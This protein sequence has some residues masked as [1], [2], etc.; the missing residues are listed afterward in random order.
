L[1][2]GIVRGELTILLWGGAFGFAWIYVVLA[3]AWIGWRVRKRLPQAHPIAAASPPLLTFTSDRLPRAPALFSWKLRVEA[4]HST[5]RHYTAILN[6]S[7]TSLTPTWPRGRYLVTARW[8]LADWFGFTR[9]TI[10]PKESVALTVE[11][12]RRE[13]HPPAAPDHRRG[14]TRPRRTGRRAG[15]PFDIRHYVPGDDLRRLHW[16][17]YAHSDSLFVRTAETVPPPTGHQFIVLDIDAASEEAL[18]YRLECLVGWLDNLDAAASEWTVVVPAARLTLDPSNREAL[19]SLSPA[20]LPPTVDTEWPETVSVLTASDETPLIGELIRSRRRVRPV[21]VIQTP[22][23]R[24][25]RTWWRR[26]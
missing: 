10:P 22:L 25:R 24:L 26:V 4:R 11:P 13:F 16:P 20:P 23:P 1:A 6:P 17:L 9:L 18:D 15:E 8:Q 7:E 21:I 12:A 5:T 14:P 19:A 3:G 2:L